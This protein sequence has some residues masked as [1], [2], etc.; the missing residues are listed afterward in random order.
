[1][2]PKIHNLNNKLYQKSYYTSL[3]IFSKIIQEVSNKQ[4]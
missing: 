2:Y 3:I 4:L 1:M